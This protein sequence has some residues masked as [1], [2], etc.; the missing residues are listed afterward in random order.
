MDD[1]VGR[2]GPA[3]ARHEKTSEIVAR[4]ARDN[5]SDTISIG[6]LLEALKDRGFGV[7]IILF[8]LPNAI[9]PIAWVLGA[10]ILIFAIQLILGSK[11]P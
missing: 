11:K 5:R 9:V 1:Q 7:I 10:P 2:V 6:Q 4:I 8:A 3:M